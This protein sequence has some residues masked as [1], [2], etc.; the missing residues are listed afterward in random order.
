MIYVYVVFLL[1]LN[2]CW[3]AG[4]LFALPGNWLMVI[5]TVLFGWWRWDDGIFGVAVLV[6]VALLALVGEA[7]EFFAGAGSAK[8]AGA[9]WAG[10]LA[11]IGG[12]ICGALFG[13]FLIPVPVLG[14]LL[15]ACA[16]AGLATWGVERLSGKAHDK[17]VK[18]GL[19]AGVGVVVGTTTKFLIG[20]LIWLIIAIAAVL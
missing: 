9:G 2:A 15:G 16:G 11:A 1:I 5:T 20:C 8:K 14:T 12:M 19:G 6:A 3:L 7:V 17:S 4:V 13:T 18:S 10:A